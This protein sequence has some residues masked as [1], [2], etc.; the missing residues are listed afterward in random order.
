MQILGLVSDAEN[1][2]ANSKAL[3]FHSQPVRRAEEGEQPISVTKP[4]S[5]DDKLI[6]KMRAAADKDAVSLH[7]ILQATA[8][9]VPPKLETKPQTD[10]ATPE[11]DRSAEERRRAIV[12]YLQSRTRM[13]STL[14]ERCREANERVNGKRAKLNVLINAQSLVPKTGMEIQ[15][16]KLAISSDPRYLEMVNRYTF[17]RRNL[18]WR[19]PAETAMFIHFPYIDFDLRPALLRVQLSKKEFFTRCPGRSSI[20]P[21]TAE[22]L[23]QQD[24]T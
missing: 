17:M 23:F 10:V 12:E 15:K 2:D 13:L 5:A 19:I 16:V 11:P 7:E 3:A 21:P 9:I 1:I 8:I 6:A 14:V 24:R 20:A 4:G 18:G 22:T